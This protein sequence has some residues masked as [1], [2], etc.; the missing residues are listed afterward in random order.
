MVDGDNGCHNGDDCEDD[1]DD[2][3]DYD[4]TAA[5]DGISGMMRSTLMAVVAEAMVV[6]IVMHNGKAIKNCEGIQ[7]NFHKKI[8]V[9]A[10]VVTAMMFMIRQRGD[11]HCSQQ[12]S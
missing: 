8:M 4:G 2:D 9:I 3:D 11:G 1:G 12:P 6:M 10:M 5:V 7:G